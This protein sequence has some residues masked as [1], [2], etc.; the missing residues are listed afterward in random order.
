[1]N[2]RP[3]RQ[4]VLGA[5]AATL[6]AV[7]LPGLVAGDRALAGGGAP[8]AAE[9][10]PVAVPD[11]L[12][13]A[14]DTP[15][16]AVVVANDTDADGDALT[17]ASVT[18]AT[19]GSVTFDGGSVTYTPA[20]NFHGSDAF[21]YAATDGA[22]QSDPVTVDVT[23]SASNDR[24]TAVE[25]AYTM[26][27]GQTNDVDPAQG[28]LAND[29]DVDEDVLTAVKGLPKPAHGSL[30]LRPDGSFAY[31]PHA[32]ACNVQDS[33]AYKARD[34]ST[35]SPA[36]TV[37]LTVET[38]R[39]LPEL[40]LAATPP[41]VGYRD[42][43]A[44]T[45]RLSGFAPGVEIQISRTA[46]GGTPRLV[47]SGPP[48]AAGVLAFTARALTR[49]TTFTARSTGDNCFLPAR[50]AARRVGVRPDVTGTLDPGPVVDG[51]RV[52]RPDQ[53][54]FYRS[55]VVPD[56]AGQPVGWTWQELQD[57]GW[58]TIFERD[59]LLLGEEGSVGFFLTGT[60]PG[61]SYRIR[62][63]FL[64][65]DDHAKTSSAWSRFRIRSSSS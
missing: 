44:L 12:G 15:G 61:H 25:D 10:A 21:T 36:T 59:D 54:P 20:S 24:P 8:T 17:V 57:G 6:F 58:V 50:A 40:L 60:T 23:V 47:A 53:D 31:T 42:S 55:L 43:V 46:L 52:Y 64:G 45:A 48:D 51:V 49:R 7:G 16:S 35:A 26:L 1:M 13:T 18:Q 63:R 38:P 33:F 41:I 9:E 22:A 29:T 11:T 5:L 19:H 37:A 28:V 34:A 39:S 4:L 62:T 65:D 3:P 32:G 2:Q 27:G 14:E 30:R 56:H